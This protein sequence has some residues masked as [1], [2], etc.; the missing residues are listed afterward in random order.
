MI[1]FLLFWIQ[2]ALGRMSISAKVMDLIISWFL[3]NFISLSFI[4]GRQNDSR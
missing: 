3:L 2:G 1:P 4:R